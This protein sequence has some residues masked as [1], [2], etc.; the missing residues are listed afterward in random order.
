MK[1]VNILNNKNVQ[2]FTFIV[3]Q[4]KLHLNYQNNNIKNNENNIKKFFGENKKDLVL[5]Y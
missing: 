2:N 3:M 4:K 5:E 1:N